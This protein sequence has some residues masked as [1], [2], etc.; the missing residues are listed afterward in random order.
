LYSGSSKFKLKGTV[1]LQ[2]KAATFSIE[3]TA[4]MHFREVEIIF[5]RATPCLSI[6]SNPLALHDSNGSRRQ[7]RSQIYSICV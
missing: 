7:T 1:Y 4:Q 3:R 6:L 5:E 2:C